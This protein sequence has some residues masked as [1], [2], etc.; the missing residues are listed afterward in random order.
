MKKKGFTLAEVL[1][2]MVVLG[3]VAVV[4]IP[5]FTEAKH[6]RKQQKKKE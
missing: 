6:E 2:A 1:V 4:A 5:L 3:V